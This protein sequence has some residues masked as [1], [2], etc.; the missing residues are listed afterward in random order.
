MNKFQK[1][2]LGRLRSEGFSPSDAPYHILATS[3]FKVAY[4]IQATFHF[5]VAYHIEVA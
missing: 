2:S 4:H 3:H 5:K 1:E